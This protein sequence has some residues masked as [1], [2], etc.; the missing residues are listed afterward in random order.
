VLVWIAPLIGVAVVVIAIAGRP[1]VRSRMPDK[2]WF[3]DSS[4]A[5]TYMSVLGTMFAVMLAFV[6]LSRCRAISMHA[7][8]RAAKPSPSPNFTSSRT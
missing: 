8:V 5:D 1:F 7:T 2:G 3:V 6:I 4:R